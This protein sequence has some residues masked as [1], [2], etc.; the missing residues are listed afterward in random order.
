M[1]YRYKTPYGTFA[2]RPQRGDPRAVEL[3][4]DPQKYCCGK[5]GS[6]REAAAAASGHR[7]GFAQWDSC[8]LDVPENLDEW[9]S[10]ST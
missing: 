2:I 10:S 4:V 9:L 1:I 5:F 8:G 6:A 3:W 7:T